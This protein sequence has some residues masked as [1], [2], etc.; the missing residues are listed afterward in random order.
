MVEAAI[1]PDIELE[2][3]ARLPGK[4][5]PGELLALMP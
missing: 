4:G 5:E 3:V 2:I 1:G